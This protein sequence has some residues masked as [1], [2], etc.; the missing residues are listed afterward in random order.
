MELL[1]RQIDAGRQLDG[2]HVLVPTTLVVRG[3]TGAP[4]A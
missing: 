2:E 1:L 4:R 3:S